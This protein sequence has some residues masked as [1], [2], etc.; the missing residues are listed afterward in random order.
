RLGV[1]RER[2]ELGRELRIDAEPLELGGRDAGIRGG[3]EHGRR[4]QDEDRCGQD[5]REDGRRHGTSSRGWK[6]GIG[7]PLLSS[8]PAIYTEVAP[9][10]SAPSVPRQRSRYVGVAFGA[11]PVARGR[12][13]AQA[14]TSPAS[15]VSN[16]KRTSV[17]ARPRR[18]APRRRR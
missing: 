3:G 18:R 9:R 7:P 10:F 12:E 5:R 15:F 6:P 13:N 2:R 1:G 16:S 14:T 17:R 8:C 4:R 11:L